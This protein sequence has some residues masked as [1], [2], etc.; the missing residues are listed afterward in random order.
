MHME[1]LPVYK[2]FTIRVA[3]EIAGA[4][5]IPRI[6]LFLTQVVVFHHLQE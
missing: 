1:E 3:I 4:M 2:P 5:S 6:R